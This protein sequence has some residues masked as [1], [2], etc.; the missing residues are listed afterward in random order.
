MKPN[1]LLNA[2]IQAGLTQ[3]ELS[4]VSQIHI[5]RL[6]HLEQDISQMSLH[7]LETLK[8]SLSTSADQILLNEKR[9]A[10]DID[11]ETTDPIYSYQ[12]IIFQLLEKR[13]MTYIPSQMDPWNDLSEMSKNKNKILFIRKCILHMTQAKF[14]KLVNVTINTVVHWEKSKTQPALEKWIILSKLSGISL[15]FLLWKD[16]PFAISA[17]GLNNNG[18]NLLISLRNYYQ[19]KEKNV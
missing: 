9:Q 15:D 14:A 17:Y 6:K 5:N 2:R 11:L 12:I 3:K 10:I 16:H 19:D 8:E 1:G 13:P 4:A 18:Y 7:E